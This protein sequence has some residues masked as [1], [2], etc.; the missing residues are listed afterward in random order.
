M[1]TNQEIS[2]NEFKSGT[3]NKKPLAL[4][5]LILT[6]ILWG[7]TFIITKTII[8]DVPIFFYLGMR[9]SIALVGFAPYIVL[10]KKMSKQIILKGFISGVLYFISI[11]T[12]TIGLET[13]TAGKAGFITGLNTIM[14]PFLAYILLKQSFR[15]KVWLAAII[16]IIGMA[17]LFLEGEQGIIVGDI[18]VLICAFTCALFIIYNDR[19][20]KTVNV[21]LFSIMQLITII[22][23]CF[24]FSFLLNESYN[25]ISFTLDFWI[26]MLYMGIIVTTLTF[27][28]QNWSQKH[29]NSATTAIIFSLEPVFA[30]LF[31]FLLGGELLSPLGFTGS[32]LILIAIFITVYKNKSNPKI[33]KENN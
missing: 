5:L 7:S 10:L 14:V 6:T 4:L 20:V 29:Q 19:V 24:F 1:E 27:L 17:F 2:N 21:Y 28:F 30:L 13:T 31:G 11:A 25:N 15:K 18:W 8:Q 33:R 3:I 16:S 26:I 32:A 22:G 23:F 12:Q 9:Y